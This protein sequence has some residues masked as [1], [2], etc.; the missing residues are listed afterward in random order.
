[1]NIIVDY[2]LCDGHGQCLLAA[3]DVFDLPDGFDQVV[4]LDEDPPVAD[5][6]TV[7]RAAAM[8]PAQAIRVL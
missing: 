3:P 7:V 1:M 8:C 4:V 2:G 5:Y 6:E